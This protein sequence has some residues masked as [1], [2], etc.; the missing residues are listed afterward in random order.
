MWDLCSEYSI[1]IQE[2]R[3]DNGSGAVIMPTYPDQLDLRLLLLNLR[4]Y[5]AA[6]ANRNAGMRCTL[7]QSY[8]P[9]DCSQWSWRPPVP[10]AKQSHCRGHQQHTYQSRIYNHRDCQPDTNF[11]YKDDL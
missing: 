1:Q 6:T 4:R 2:S 9:P 3:H 5:T 8:P 10:P 11:L 7:A